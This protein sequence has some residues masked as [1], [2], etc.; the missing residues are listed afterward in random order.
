MCGAGYRLPNLPCVNAFARTEWAGQL[1]ENRKGILPMQ[2]A[3]DERAW[4][5]SMEREGSMELYM[6]RR[7]AVQIAAGCAASPLLSGFDHD[8]THAVSQGPAYKAGAPIRRDIIDPGTPGRRL[9][10][11]GRVL[12]SA[13]EKPV[14]Q[15]MLDLWNVQ[16]NGEY[17]F[18][19]FNLRGRQ[20]S[21]RE[22]NF[23]FLTIEAIP[24]GSR[25]AHFH[26]KVSAPGFQPLTTEL[27][28]PGLAHNERDSAFRTSNLL[29][30]ES[31]SGIRKGRYD[32]YLRQL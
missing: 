2:S 8:P 24:Y 29:Q 19:G 12:S 26:F 21:G 17:D 11:R 31:E 23:E 28:L 14:E 6:T 5:T 4:Y 16:T 3:R 32:F 25:T 10:L 18:D 20:L 1:I 13:T 9:L 27:Y 7:R 30:T 22:G 15:A